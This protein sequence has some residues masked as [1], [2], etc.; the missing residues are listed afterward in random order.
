MTT[1]HYVTVGFKHVAVLLKN[2]LKEHKRKKYDTYVIPDT[3]FES[4]R[5][6]VYLITL[7]DEV[8][9]IGETENLQHRLS[10]YES[11]TGPT[12]VRLREHLVDQKEY[13]IYFLDTPSYECGFGGVQV[14]AGISYKD[15]EKKLLIQY[16]ENM[17]RLPVLNK[18]LK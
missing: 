6:G 12:N 4:K 3:V 2:T 15:L 13:H 8:L 11:H 7:G 1:L 16:R 14:Q 18:G 17:N 10:C 5:K 9:K